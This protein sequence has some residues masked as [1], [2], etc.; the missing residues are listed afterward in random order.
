MTHGITIVCPSRRPHMI[1][2][3]LANYARQRGV[4]R[5]LI[6]CLHGV[7]PNLL[8]LKEAEAL[9]GVSFLR[10]EAT[11][12][13]G[14]LLNRAGLEVETPYI[15]KWDDDDFYGA[16]FLTESVTALQRNR[17]RIVGKGGWHAWI[18]QRGKLY[19]R[20]NHA[21]DRR[22]GHLAGGTLACATRDWL[23]IGF[24]EI[25]L[26]ED[27]AFVKRFISLGH[28]SFATSKYNYAQ[29]RGGDSADHTWLI[30]DEDYLHG[31]EFVMNGLV[32]SAFEKEFGI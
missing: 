7:E 15:C 24:P 4:E 29:Y 26:G 22:S 31:S 20:F 1:G 11:Q 16:G 9:G 8:D 14:E 21:C 10:F 13:L 32:F 27:Q 2:R 30:S 23:E 17:G 18:E 12:T 3:L 19:L 25:S 6:V 28:T 5:Q